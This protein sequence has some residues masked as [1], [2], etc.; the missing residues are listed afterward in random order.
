MKSGGIPKHILL[1]IS[2]DDDNK[3]VVESVRDAE[4]SK[5]I[6]EDRAH[7]KGCQEVIIDNKGF[8]IIKVVSFNGN[9]NTGGGHYIT[10]CTDTTNFYKF[11]ANLSIGASIEIMNS[12][13][14]NNLLNDFVFI[15][16]GGI[17]LAKFDGPIY[18]E[19]LAAQN[20]SDAKPLKK[21][22]VGDV[23]SGKSGNPVVFMGV[24]DNIV[25]YDNENIGVYDYNQ[26][27]YKTRLVKKEYKPS[28]VFMSKSYFT[29]MDENPLNN[30]KIV[31][32]DKDYI[33]QI[34]VAL[35]HSYKTLEERFEISPDWLDKLIEKHR[36]TSHY[37]SPSIF[38]LKDNPV[39]K[40][41]ETKYNSQSA[42]PSA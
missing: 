29:V 21:L 19:K 22:Q 27:C 39:R 36:G 14:R 37:C 33:P 1:F 31:Q 41:L 18:A 24:F 15:R 42:P 11:N 38:A 17:H 40:A 7:Y 35:S 23:V 6:K 13:D 20:V 25:A 30:K 32:I 28:M 26:R 2:R 5:K 16:D 10:E 8:R 34:Q 4:D 9:I 3:V 12:L